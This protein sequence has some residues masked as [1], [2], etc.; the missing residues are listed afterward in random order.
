MEKKKDLI[1]IAMMDSINLLLIGSKLIGLSLRR[2]VFAPFLWNAVT[3]ADFK[4]DRR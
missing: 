4:A 3:L 1:S 2:S